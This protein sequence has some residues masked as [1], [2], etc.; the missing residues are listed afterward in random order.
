M[1]PDA[2]EFAVECHDGQLDRAGA[3]FLGH[4]LRVAAYVTDYTSDER[5]IAAA[6]LHDSVEDCDDVEL[7]LITLKFGERVAQYVDVLTKREG[8]KYA[9]YIERIATAPEKLYTYA[10]VYIKLADLRDNM[11]PRRI[12][13]GDAAWFDGML[14]ERY[15][16]ARDRLREV[17]G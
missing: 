3:P 10:P 9:D 8:E 2:L 7:E 1:I 4:P 12:T 14:R 16:P 17:L 6:A 15:M 13:L 11:D 5:V